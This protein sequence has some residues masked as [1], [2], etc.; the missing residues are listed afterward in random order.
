[1]DTSQRP[2]LRR[3][4]LDPCPELHEAGELLDAAGQAIC[5]GEWTRAAGLLTRANNPTV[6][7][8]GWRTCGPLSIEVHRA[9]RLPVTL[10]KTER[11]P[12][13]M[14]GAA[15][16]RQIFTRD[17]W[18]CRFCGVRVISVAARRRL[19]TWFPDVIPWPRRERERHAA[20]F[21]LEASIDHVFPHSRGGT[22]DETNFVT[23]CY[24]CQHG[25]GQFL[26]EESELLDPRLFPPMV[27]GWDG[28]TRLL[29]VPVSR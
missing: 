14:P 3:A 12:T 25:R 2:Q 24:C 8:H 28:L 10:P 6:H 17:G 19:R 23:A 21:F 20:L 4:L 18:R 9:T 29:S 27:D 15:V 26:L 5:A 7:A 1:V 22:N 11:D 13:R 16:Q